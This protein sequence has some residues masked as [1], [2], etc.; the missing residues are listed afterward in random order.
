M[1]T[2]NK[3]LHQLDRALVW[4]G[5]MQLVPIS[6]F[7]TIFG[8]AFGLSATQTGL[9]ESTIVL[10]SALVFAGAAQFAALELW[11]S[12]LRIRR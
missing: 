9:D 12:H 7:V 5:F 11:G 3:T 1:A 10:M 2:D 6:L 4:S 8:V